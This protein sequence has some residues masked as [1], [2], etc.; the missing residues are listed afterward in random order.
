MVTSILLAIGVALVISA[1]VMFS[2]RAKLKSVRAQT[3]A[4]NYERSGSFG[5]NI[6]K[7]TFLFRNITRIP[8]AQPRRR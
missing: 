2:I 3:S 1:I 4:C 6:Q 8:R 5:L 7:D